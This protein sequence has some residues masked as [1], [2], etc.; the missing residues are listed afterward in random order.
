MPKRTNNPSK[1]ALYMRE[2]NRKNRVRL[3]KQRAAH[4]KQ[5][6]ELRAKALKRAQEWYAQHKDR[7]LER[8]RAHYRQNKERHVA[9]VK[10][11]IERNKER[12]QE[13][14]HKYNSDRR[15]KLR[16]LMDG[17]IDWEAVA[18]RADGRCG[19]CNIELA[20]PVE[21][22]HIVPVVLG[23]RHATDNL[24]L[25]HRRCNRMKGAKID[26]KITVPEGTP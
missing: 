11:W 20:V 5:N 23:G 26:F 15:C 8:G 12:H 22:D 3:L 1:H 21:F 19:I 14:H 4:Y 24:Q 6:P 25:V 7:G 10:K 18:A 16:G 17:K 9:N 2:W 13:Y